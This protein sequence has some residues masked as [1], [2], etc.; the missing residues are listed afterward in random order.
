[1]G[2]HRRGLPPG[3]KAIRAFERQPESRSGRSRT[4][5][6]LAFLA[7]TALVL[8]PVIDPST[9]FALTQRADIVETVTLEGQTLTASGDF[10]TEDYSRDTFKITV[11]VQEVEKAASNAPAAGKPDPGSAKA[12]A[13]AMVE[14]R[15][16]NDKQFDCLVALW[17]RESHWNIYAH[18]KGSGAYGIPQ[19]LPGAKMA[20][21][22]SDWATSAKTQIKWGLGY[23]SARY[24]NPCG[25]WASSE[26]RGWY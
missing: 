24:D 7:C 23:I 18:N 22:G 3:D 19:A 17:N 1:V 16:W 15:G 11:T 21:A 20:S 2:K 6:A 14:K 13:L 5:A 10:E 9:A 26:E 12:I 4:L 8:V 25:A